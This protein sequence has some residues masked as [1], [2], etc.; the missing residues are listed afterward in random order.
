MIR[1]PL[2]GAFTTVSYES[3]VSAASPNSQYFVAKISELGLEGVGYWC[4]QHWCGSTCMVITLTDVCN[5]RVKTQKMHF[6]FLFE[7]TSD[8]QTTMY[9]EPHQCPL[10]Q[11][12]LL[13]K[14]P[15]TNHSNFCEKILRI[16]GAEKWHLL[17][18]FC[19][20]LFV[21]FSQWISP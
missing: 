15:R 5:K 2:D 21:F 20:W 9:V 13:S 1:M 7:L 17:L 4:K 10:H 11:F 18:S 8:S 12:I 14:Y 16:E 19:L 3:I 6:Y